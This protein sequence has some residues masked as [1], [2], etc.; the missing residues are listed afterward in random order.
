[1]YCIVFSIGENYY[2]HHVDG[3][4][5]A[6]ETIEGIRKALAF[7]EHCPF[8]KEEYIKALEETNPTLIKAPDHPSGLSKYDIEN[9]D[10][11]YMHRITDSGGISGW[12]TSK[13]IL[14]LKVEDVDLTGELLKE[15][16]NDL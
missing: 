16:R 11:L 15:L 14:E 8:T 10:N 2:L 5:G 7:N 3:G 6:D 12:P 1:M 13:N 9:S 4:V